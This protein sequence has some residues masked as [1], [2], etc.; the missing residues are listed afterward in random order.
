M[1]PI[2]E[3]AFEPEEI[4]KLYRYK[5]I[6]KYLLKI[7]TE[8]EL[9]TDL[10]NLHKI[11]LGMSQ[12]PTCR[13]TQIAG[14]RVKRNILETRYKTTKPTKTRSYCTPLVLTKTDG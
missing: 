2:T 7:L 11:I 5:K 4:I 13:L 6:K 9:S 10:E 12:L 3:Y 14:N 8:N 1:F